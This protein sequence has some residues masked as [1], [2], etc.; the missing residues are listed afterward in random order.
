VEWRRGS[1]LLV[2]QAQRSILLVVPVYL[3]RVGRSGR[4]A[5]APR[6]C[7]RRISE[8]NNKLQICV[9]YNLELI[10]SFQVLLNYR[11]SPH[12]YSFHL[13]LHTLSAVLSAEPPWLAREVVT[14][15]PPKFNWVMWS[16]SLDRIIPQPFLGQIMR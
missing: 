14:V 11:I 8:K 4:H 16:T 10:F 3:S 2:E 5:S 9:S 15:D 13:K 7:V 12:R 6:S 1:P